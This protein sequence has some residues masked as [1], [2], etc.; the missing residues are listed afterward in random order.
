MVRY[1]VYIHAGNAYIHATG[2]DVFTKRAQR[3]GGA[4]FWLPRTF[5]PFEEAVEESHGLGV[6]KG[7]ARCGTGEQLAP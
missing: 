4:G 6:T 3:H 2:C 5:S 1:A 7:C